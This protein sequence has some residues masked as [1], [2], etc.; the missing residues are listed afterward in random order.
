MADESGVAAKAA[1]RLVD[2]YYAA[3]L[4]KVRGSVAGDDGSVLG[5]FARLT[6]APSN[7]HQATVFALGSD[8]PED[9]ALNARA[10]AMFALGVFMV[11]LQCVTMPRL[12]IASL[13]ESCVTQ[14][15]C[16][17][18]GMFCRRS[19]FGSAD[20]RQCSYCGTHAPLEHQWEYAAD[21]A[22]RT[23]NFPE[24]QH[25]R[26]EPF[27]DVGFNRTHVLSVCADPTKSHSV[28]PAPGYGGHPWPLAFTC[29]RNE[30]AEPPWER[31]P[32]VC[33]GASELGE[34]SPAYEEYVRAWCHVCGKCSRSLSVFLKAQS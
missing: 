20:Q 4:D 9:A 18:K 16:S 27:D 22:L 14:D 32:T 25:H 23:Y 10:P 24:D 28:A 8:A 33:P 13:S 15:D 21:G 29:Y 19:P 30:G 2:E 5:V 26:A 7:W 34:P 11:L 6:E 12:F 31:V 3:E 1:L 17:V